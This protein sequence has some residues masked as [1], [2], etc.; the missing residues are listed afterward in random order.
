MERELK[1]GPFV[2]VAQGCTGVRLSFIAA[3][4]VPP[5]VEGFLR[6]YRRVI[7]RWRLGRTALGRADEI[8][9]R[10]N[11]GGALAL[12]LRRQRQHCELRAQDRDHPPDRR[13]SAEIKLLQLLQRQA[14]RQNRPEIASNWSDDDWL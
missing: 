12:D 2:C 1:T 14:T 11:R 3:F 7:L 6:A 4:L 5:S 8:Q 9:R 10:R 13:S